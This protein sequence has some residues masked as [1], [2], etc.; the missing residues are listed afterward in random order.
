V[1]DLN[2]KSMNALQMLKEQE[3]KVDNKLNN[4]KMTIN[5]HSNKLENDKVQVTMEINYKES[6]NRPLEIKQ[7][8]IWQVDLGA[9]RHSIQGGIR[10]FLVTSNELNNRY[11]PNISGCAITSQLGKSKLPIHV[12]I[13]NFEECGLKKKSVILAE[14][15]CPIDKKTQFKYKI[16]TVT[17]D[18]MEQVEQA[19]RIQNG[20]LKPKTPLERLPK[21]MQ[22][23]IEEILDDIYTYEKALS[24]AKNKS[25]IKNLLEQREAFLWSLQKFCEDNKLNYRDYYKMYEKKEEKIA[26]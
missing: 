11:S 6:V 17:E 12:E 24:K 13:D 2:E 1:L 7:Y 21:Y 25:L 3:V 23:N 18:I 16:G 9:G 26:M 20:R 4:D 8:E 15:L 22:D 5:V 10:P 14:T 19:I